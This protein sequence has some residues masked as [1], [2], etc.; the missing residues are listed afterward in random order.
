MGMLAFLVKLGLLQLVESPQWKHYP[1]INPV[2]LQKWEQSPV[3]VD[4][5]A[6]SHSFSA[7]PPLPFL[8]SI[9]L[10]LLL[11]RSDC[12]HFLQ[13]TASRGTRVYFATCGDGSL[14]RQELAASCCWF[15]TCVHP[16]TSTAVCPPPQQLKGHVK[17][18]DMRFIRLQGAVETRFKT[19][20]KRKEYWGALTFRHKHNAAGSLEANLFFIVCFCHSKSC[21][22]LQLN[23]NSPV[24]KPSQWLCFQW[25]SWCSVSFC[26][27]LP[28]FWCC[29]LLIE[30]SLADLGSR[31]L[32]AAF[33]STGHSVWGR[34][35]SGWVHLSWSGCRGEQ[36]QSQALGRRRKWRKNV[37]R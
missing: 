16:F 37:I 26:S 25:K 19:V 6:T 27:S 15:L 14:P 4:K 34:L 28:V 33:L 22:L 8:L 5:P 20:R 10:S 35:W 29:V 18:F 31:A 21:S 9:F 11:S 23:C 7:S 1:A 12:L 2:Y 24:G 30:R 13:Q 32:I 3:K 17:P 36:E